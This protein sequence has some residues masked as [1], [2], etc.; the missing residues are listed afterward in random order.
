MKASIAGAVSEGE[1]LYLTKKCE[2]LGLA[3]E[4]VAKE[5]GITDL[6]ALTTDGFQAIKDCL[7]EKS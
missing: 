6:S 3:L 2:A 4:D 7:M 5:V 1:H